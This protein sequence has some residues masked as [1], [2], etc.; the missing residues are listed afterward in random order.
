MVQA[1]FPRHSAHQIF[2]NKTGVRWQN[3]FVSNCKMYL[4]QI[5]KCICLK[6]QNIFVSN[7]KMYL[8]QIAKCI[9]LKL[10]NVHVSN[11]KM[12]LYNGWHCGAW[13]YRA[14]RSDLH[15]AR[16]GQEQLLSSHSWTDG[17]RGAKNALNMFMLD[18]ILILAFPIFGTPAL[19]LKFLKF[20][21]DFKRVLSYPTTTD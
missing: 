14:V 2:I 9:C 11:R 3:V 18:I 21:T 16:L 13:S 15:G 6:L 8:S 5:A 17:G 7:C 1:A 10:Q 4:C 20:T 12:Y 19:S